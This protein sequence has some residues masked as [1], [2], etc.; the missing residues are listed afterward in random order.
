MIGSTMPRISGRARSN[1]VH[2]RPTDAAL[3]SKWAMNQL[4]RSS[5]KLGDIVGSDGLDGAPRDL[6]SSP[7]VDMSSTRKFSTSSATST[8][9]GAPSLGPSALRSLRSCCRFCGRAC[10]LASR[11]GDA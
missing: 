11:R 4:L 8:A 1:R 7:G 6:S 10:R 2:V 9:N 3:F 5:E